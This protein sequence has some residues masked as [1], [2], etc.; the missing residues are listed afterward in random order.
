MPSSLPPDP[1][2]HIEPDLSILLSDADR[3]LGIL[4][5][6]SSIL[7]DAHLFAPLFVRH[8]AVLSCQIDGNPSSLDELLQFEINPK[9]RYLSADAR[10]VFNYT[11]AMRYGL[12]CLQKED[13]GL[14]LICRTHG[15]LM[16]RVKINGKRGEFRT[17]Q[18]LD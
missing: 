18:T 13:L 4:N 1:P 14:A 16:K 12:R 8:E 15:E 17:T 10:S 7:E 3:E 2:V 5:G 9:G 6:A 11:Q